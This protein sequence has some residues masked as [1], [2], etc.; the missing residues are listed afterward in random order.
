MFNVLFLLQLKRNI[1]KWPVIRFK[2]FYRTNSIIPIVRCEELRPTRANIEEISASILVCLAR[3][4]S[5]GELKYRCHLNISWKSFRFYHK[6]LVRIFA[7]FKLYHIHQFVIFISL[8]S[9]INLHFYRLATILTN[10]WEKSNVIVLGGQEQ[11]CIFSLNKY[12]MV[13]FINRDLF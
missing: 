5:L 2:L 9:F 4:F 10:I 8:W 12:P 1:P 7:L 11:R 13:S 3:I 6:S